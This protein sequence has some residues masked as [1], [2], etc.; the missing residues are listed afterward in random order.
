MN[1]KLLTCRIRTAI[2]LVERMD[3]DKKTHYFADNLKNRIIS[4][5]V[6]KVCRLDPSFVMWR[7]IEHEIK[8]REAIS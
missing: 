3:M 2:S 7:L 5:I 4:K 1:E 8:M 6:S